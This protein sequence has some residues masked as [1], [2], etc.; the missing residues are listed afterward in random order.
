MNHLLIESKVSILRTENLTSIWGGQQKMQDLIV[1]TGET[2]NDNDILVRRLLN[3][4]S[5]EFNIVPDSG[6][7]NT[8]S[9]WGQSNFRNLNTINN[10]SGDLGTG[11]LFNGQFGIDTEILPDLVTGL[12]TSISSSTINLDSSSVG[13]IEFL[14]NSTQFNPYIGWTSADNSA[15][16]RSMFG[17]GFGEIAA[18]QTGFEIKYI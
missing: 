10:G 18:N 3:Q 7:V 14:T 15:E 8:I 12:G 17:I 9:A 2:I 4:A 5:F 1:T 16:L 11:E 6:F 13:D